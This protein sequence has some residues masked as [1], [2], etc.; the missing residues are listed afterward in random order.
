MAV[1]TLALGVFGKL[2]LWKALA[3]VADQHP[4]IAALDLDELIDRAQSQYELLERE[5]LSAGRRSFA[6]DGA[7]ATS[8]AR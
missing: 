7:A 4:E 3:Q 8:A 2:S 5:R 1:E 6:R